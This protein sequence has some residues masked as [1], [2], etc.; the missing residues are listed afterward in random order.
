MDLSGEVNI[1]AEGEGDDLFASKDDILDG[2]SCLVPCIE[3]DTYVYY[4]STEMIISYLRAKSAEGLKSQ[5]R[6]II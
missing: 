4:F 5:V 2:K 6:L 3:R 1:E